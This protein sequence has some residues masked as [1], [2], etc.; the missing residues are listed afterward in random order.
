MVYMALLIIQDFYISVFLLNNMFVLLI[1]KK[2]IPKITSNLILA[3]KKIFKK[4]LG[5]PTLSSI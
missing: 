3:I 5:L 1:F 2:S 4:N